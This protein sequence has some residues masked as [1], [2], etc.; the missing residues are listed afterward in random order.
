MGDVCSIDDL[1]VLAPKSPHLEAQVGGKRFSSEYYDVAD[2]P[3]SWYRSETG[4]V[5]LGVRFLNGLLVRN[6]NSSVCQNEP[7]ER[8]QIEHRES[9]QP[10][11][12]PFG[13]SLVSRSFRQQTPLFR[14]FS[15]LP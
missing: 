12:I 1:A 7:S 13:D 4:S 5:D 3:P 15:A 8:F 14:A 9:N 11:I 6:R 10:K 2:L